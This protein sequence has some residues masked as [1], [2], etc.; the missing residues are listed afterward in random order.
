M[1]KRIAQVSPVL[2]ALFVLAVVQQAT[3]CAEDSPT[4]GAEP[5]QKSERSKD[6]AKSKT[7][8]KSKPLVTLS[9][10][11]TVLTEPVGKDG[12]VDYIAA[13]NQRESAGLTPETN[14]GVFFV[15]ALDLDGNSP[16]YRKE[17]FRLLGI[18][19]NPE[20]GD[21]LIGFHKWVRNK[22]GRDADEAENSAIDAAMSGPW[23]AK[24]YPLVAEW[25]D[26]QDAKLNLL[27]EGTRRERCYFPLVRLSN[28]DMLIGVL[29]PSVQKSRDAARTLIARVM[30]NLHD[31]KVKEGRQDLLALHR[32]GR[33]VGNSPFLIGA[34]VGVAIESMAYQAD[35]EFLKHGN[36]SS[37][38]ALA[39]QAD[40]RNL[41]LRRTMA[42]EIDQTERMMVVDTAT[43][44]ARD[45]LSK[46]R[47]VD[48]G[49]ESTVMAA[50]EKVLVNSATVDWDE[51]LKF[52]N[53]EFDKLTA[54]AKLPTSIERAQELEKLQEEFRGFH[55][56]VSDPFTF[57]AALLK[58]AASRQSMGQLM[59]RMLS[60][61]L[62][63]AVSQACE[64]ENRI[65]MRISLGQIGCAMA[66]YYADHKGYP[67][68]LD[69]LA[70]KYIA[71]VPNDI[72]NEQPLHYM[73]EADGSGYLVYSIGKNGTDE[74]G[75]TFGSQPK[76]DDLPLQVYR[77]PGQ[78]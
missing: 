7:N 33:L 21:Y 29:L 3:L 74:G 73:P 52:I 41:P 34:L 15:R 37:K 64:A 24:D 11:T 57:A 45:G 20:E 27:I 31:G 10:E 61:M 44:V 39:F 25:L 53:Q 14:A 2:G 6:A 23:S 59:G 48:G 47:D 4:K 70:P 17:Y 1:F 13:I 56:E 18:D 50:V 55:A 26:A 19:A 30:R 51:T 38:D 40:L 5:K 76:G 36:L 62:L 42:D 66:A 58:G 68:T 54:A 22:F 28:D 60:S 69:E 67:K 9:K 65:E 75:L 32:L 49:N 71:K 63:P 12:Y 8:S 78:N 72:Y 35:V 43:H 77:T 46:L 16:E